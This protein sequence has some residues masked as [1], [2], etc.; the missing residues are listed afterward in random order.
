MSAS[1]LNLIPLTS[2]WV[3]SEKPD[4]S[5]YTLTYNGKTID[6]GVPPTN[7]IF[8]NGIYKVKRL[9]PNVEPELLDSTHYYYEI[10]VRDL[11]T[12]SSGIY[13]FAS[14]GADSSLADGI[15]QGVEPTLASYNTLTGSQFGNNGLHTWKGRYT[16]GTR[17]DGGPIGPGSYD[18]GWIDP[19]YKPYFNINAEFFYRWSIKLSDPV[20]VIY[21]TEAYYYVPPEQVTAAHGRGVFTNVNGTWRKVTLPSIRNNNYAIDDNVTLNIT[22]IGGGGG[23]GGNDSQGG[24]SGYPGHKLT[25]TY[26][27]N[28]HKNLDIHIGG[29]G[30]G[31]VTS[32]GSGGAAGGAGGTSTLGYNGGPGSAAGPVPWSGGGGGGGAA[33]IITIDG[34]LPPNAGTIIAGGGGGGGGGGNYSSGQGQ[35][36]YQ[37]DSG[38]PTGG[39]GA[40]KG[41]DGGGAGGGGGGQPGGSGGAVAGGDSGGYS[42]MDGADSS[43]FPSFSYGTNGGGGGGGAGGCGYCQIT[44]QSPIPNQPLYTGGVVTTNGT[45]ITHTFNSIV[46]N[47]GRVEKMTSIDLG[48]WRSVQNGYVNVKGTWRQFWPSNVVADIIVVGG[49]GGGGTGYGWEGGGGGGAGGLL[50]ASGMELSISKAYNVMVGAGGGPNA[51]GGDSF[52]GAGQPTVSIPGVNVPVYAGTYPVY[53]GFLNTYGVWYDTSFSSGG[54]SA[55]YTVRITTPGTYRLVCSADNQI[56]TYVDGVNI[57]NNYAW[58]TTDTG[59]VF[60]AAGNH[61][62]TCNAGNYGGPALF[63]AAL[64]D[65]YSNLI[66]HSR[67]TAPIQIPGDGLSAIGGG[68][69]GWGSPDSTA[70]SGGSGGGGCGYAT[71][72]A[73]G[74]GISGQGHDG[75][76]GV[77][78]GY[79]QAGGGGGGGANGPGASPG[80]NGGGGGG[81]GRR[82]E[83]ATSTITLGGGGGGGWGSQGPT[84]LGVAGPAGAGGGGQG[85][86]GNGVPG[87]GGGGGGSAH[88][89][90]SATGSGGS[91]GVYIIYPGVPAFTGGEIITDQGYVIHK[92]IV[93]GTFTLQN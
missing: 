33:S 60:L 55:T 13:R 53:N 42:G 83:F 35:S 41:G 27:V 64:Y 63:A 23:G 2:G 74:T 3:W 15:Q 26:T 90:L 88:S 29:G 49:G 65:Q 47:S 72:H 19:R 82:L 25:G 36:G 54:G 79:G 73:G 78:Q 18:S 20:F 43:M 8:D 4:A 76:T 80:G 16:R 5:F 57:V 87:T 44:Y 85:N 40:G 21:S 51:N 24:H 75:A 71:T 10:T 93:P 92:F 91:G 38:G 62:I 61:S 77:W 69:G 28:Q 11:S 22:L 67:M 66:W 12:D 17:G 48:P 81:D 9:V 58:W 70:G 14:Y 32:P 52:F 7:G 46:T 34:A 1:N 50:T 39:P 56:L 30:G 59:S 6:S 68:N 89:A 31:G 86:G 37:T 45:A 84:G